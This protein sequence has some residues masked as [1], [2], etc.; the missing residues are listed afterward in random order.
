MHPVLMKDAC[1]ARPVNKKEVQANPKAQESLD[2]E[3]KRLSDRG[4]GEAHPREWSGV[5]REANESREPV[6]T[7]FMFDFCVEKNSGMAPE[8]RKYKGRAVFQ[9]NAVVDQNYDAAIFQ[10][11]CSQPTAMEAPKAADAGAWA[12]WARNMWMCL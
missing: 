6:H 7:G 10:D 11:L 4:W 2:V 12:P 8:K 3:W 5:R 1:V 9:G